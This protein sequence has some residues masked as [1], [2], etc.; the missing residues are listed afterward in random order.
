[1]I[2]EDD[3]VIVECVLRSEVLRYRTRGLVREEAEKQVGALVDQVWGQV[4]RDALIGTYG[5]YTEAL[6]GIGGNAILA[7]LKETT[8]A[9]ARIKPEFTASDL[10]TGS[11]PFRLE[12]QAKWFKEPRIGLQHL[13]HVLC[14]DIF[15]RAVS[16]IRGNVEVKDISL[17]RLGDE[18]QA[19]FRTRSH[20]IASIRT[21]FRLNHTA[22]LFAVEEEYAD[23]PLLAFSI[24]PRNGLDQV[25]FKRIA[26]GVLR[27]GFNIVEADVRNIDFM[28]AGWRSTFAE[29]AATALTIKTHVARF[30]MNIS[31][32]ADIAVRFAEDF[33]AM[34]PPEGPWVVKVDGGLDGLS[35]IQA[36]RSHFTAD[37][38]PI[39]TC[40]PILGETFARKIGADTYFKM[41]SLSGADIIYP[42][43]APRFGGGD[44]V[45]FAHAER[46]VRRYQDMVERGW[47][48][49]SV[50]GGVH[51]GQLPAYYEIFGPRVAYFLG[52][53]VALHRGGAFFDVSK[54][55]GWFSKVSE[56][57]KLG[58]PID[59]KQQVGGAELCRFALE[60]AATTRDSSKLQDMLGSTQEHYE[61]YEEGRPRSMKYQFVDPKRILKGSIRSF[62][63][64]G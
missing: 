40:Y 42:G 59:V 48:M 14:G 10:D 23:M 20:D 35:T 47:P 36:L 30:S 33:Q 54:P 13:I 15:N 18:M 1:M 61:E 8:D 17:G 64:K 63:E 29:I 51:A 49:P 31:G 5:D 24:K 12:L 34:H 6:F 4:C 44:F 25:N 55:K 3:Y 21:L 9:T 50:A 46:G 19:H 60:T 53:G 26:E 28:D 27:A 62:R 57:P 37:K 7:R 58:T 22:L 56:K 41:L 39:V 38:Q 11:V 2:G 45:D 52:G 16:E 32:P 43:G